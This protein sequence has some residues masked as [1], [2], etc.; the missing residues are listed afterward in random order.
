MVDYAANNFDCM[1]EDDTAI[2]GTSFNAFHSDNESD[3]EYILTG[4][5]GLPGRALTDYYIF[6]ALFLKN[7]VSNMTDQG[8]QE[9]VVPTAEILSAVIA[10]LSAGAVILPPEV[11]EAVIF[12]LITEIESVSELWEVLHG[13]EITFISLGEI[14]TLNL[15]YRDFLTVFMN[16]VPDDLLLSRMLVIIER[17]F[18]DYIVGMS[19]ETDYGGNTIAYEACYELYE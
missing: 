7:L 2:D 19:V 12:I 3:S 5:E 15:D 6:S 11:Y 16:F 4:L 1:L 13:G 9:I 10:V 8:L 14:E 18:P 17:D